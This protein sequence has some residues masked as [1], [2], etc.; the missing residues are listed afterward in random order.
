[1]KKKST[2]SFIYVKNMLLYIY[3]RGNYIWKVEWKNII[4]MI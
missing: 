4:E 2:K 1:M 3:S